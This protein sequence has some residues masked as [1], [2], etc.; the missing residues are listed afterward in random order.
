MK[1]IFSYQKEKKNLIRKSYRRMARTRGRGKM[2]NFSFRASPVF[3]IE[4][5]G[6][7]P[8]IAF[9]QKV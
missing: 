8:N 2:L 5:H 9:A 4:K 3:I 1:V 6:P 7:R